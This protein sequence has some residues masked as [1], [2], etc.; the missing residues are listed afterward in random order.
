M[1]W[2]YGYFAEDPNY[3]NGVRAIVEALYEPP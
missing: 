2:I 1:G 3:K